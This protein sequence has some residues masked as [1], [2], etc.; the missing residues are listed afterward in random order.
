MG[1]KTKVAGHGRFHGPFL[2]QNCRSTFSEAVWLS[3][4]ERACASWHGDLNRIAGGAGAL[5]MMCR[6]AHREFL[7]P[8]FR[9]YRFYDRLS[10]GIAQTPLRLV[11][12]LGN[13]PRG[14]PWT[15]ITRLVSPV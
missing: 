10:P 7:L 9:R 4:R 11:T 8:A 1:C 14:S 15:Y 2:S 12:R 3:K 13:R 5:S 6:S